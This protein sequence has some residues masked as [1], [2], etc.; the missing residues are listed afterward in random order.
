M[1]ENYCDDI[2]ITENSKNEWER[3][4]DG[5]PLYDSFLEQFH[6]GATLFD[7]QQDVLRNLIG[8]RNQNKRKAKWFSFLIYL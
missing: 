1:S 8:D 2:Q 6:L 3:N 7:I 4:V 5:L